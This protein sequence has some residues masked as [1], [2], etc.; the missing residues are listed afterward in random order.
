VISQIGFSVKNLLERPART[1]IIVLTTTN[2]IAER[3]ST[4][5]N[6]TDFLNVFRLQD[7]GR[8]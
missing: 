7:A 6:F 5:L 8:E 3:Q 2:N 1:G 4:L